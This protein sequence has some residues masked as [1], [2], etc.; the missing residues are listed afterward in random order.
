MEGGSRTHDHPEF[1]HSAIRKEQPQR[2]NVI[3]SYPPRKEKGIAEPSYLLPLDLPPPE[4]LE[5]FDSLNF[6]ALGSLNFGSLNFWLLILGSL[7]LDSLE[8]KLGSFEPPPPKKCDPPPL[9]P[10]NDSVG[11]RYACWTEPR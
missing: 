9:D 5:P 6:G 3:V 1:G 4:P 7:K 11:C 10:A 8:P 2:S